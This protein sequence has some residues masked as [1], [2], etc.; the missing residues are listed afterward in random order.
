MEEIMSSD[1][2]RSFLQ[3]SQQM[4]A[5]WTGIISRDFVFTIA[6]IVAIWSYFLKA[7]IES[8]SNNLA[9]GLSFLAVA[10]GLTSIMLG[11]W[12]LYTRYIYNR[13]AGLYPDLLLCEKI[14]GIESHQGTAGYLQRSIPRLRQILG[15]KQLN[16]DQKLEV[17]AFLFDRK[18]LGRKSHIVLDF[19]VVALIITMFVLCVGVHSN[20]QLPLAIG[21]IIATIVGFLLVLCG[22]FAFQRYPSQSIIKTAI[23]KYGEE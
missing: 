9:N 3:S 4:R 20:I 13:V 7:Y 1:E 2:V 22:I 15:E 19:I 11:L 17:I 23:T 18:S 12:R 8:G 14:L 5:L 10:A 6:F 21:T 16:P